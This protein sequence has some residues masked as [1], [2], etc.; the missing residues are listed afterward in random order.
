MSKQDIAIPRTVQAVEQRSQAARSVIVQKVEN[1]YLKNDASQL[2]AL[3]Q[4]F[5][6]S[7]KF[8]DGTLKIESGVIGGLAIDNGCIHSTKG[9]E[10][11]YKTTLPIVG[12][13][14]VTAYL[15]YLMNDEG[16]RCR[17][18]L[19]DDFNAKVKDYTIWEAIKMLN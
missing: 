1:T 14:T 18:C 3:L 6:P 8:E 7:V 13:T 12:E 16:I 11:P 4:S 5:A 19:T 9:E 10:I 15:F 17:V 2:M